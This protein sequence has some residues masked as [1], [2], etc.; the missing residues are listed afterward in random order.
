VRFRILLLIAGIIISVN[1]SC[2]E[3]GG[4][5]ID[6]GEI[7]YNIEYIGTT[8]TFSK[9]LMPKNLVVSFKDNKI[10]FEIMAPIG[11]SGIFNLVNPELNLY[12]TYINFVGTRLYYAG[13]P[14]EMHPGFGSMAGMEVRKTNRTTVM[15][16]YNFIMSGIP[17]KLKL[18][19]QI[20]R[21]HST[22]LTVYF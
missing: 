8:G 15:C 2:R 12:D 19:T 17:M 11:N 14:G 6:Q 20:C 4:K 21:H 16:G 10:L 9:D 18:K 7:H 13:K 3:K 5:F 1:F 22:K